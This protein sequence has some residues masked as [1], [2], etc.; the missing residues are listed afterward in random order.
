MLDRDK[1]KTQNKIQKMVAGIG[2]I[3]YPVSADATK[4]SLL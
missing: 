1:K 4:Q 3:K 2:E